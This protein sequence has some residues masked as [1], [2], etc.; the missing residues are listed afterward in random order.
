MARKDDTIIYQQMSR[1]LQ[2]STPKRN[3]QTI[4]AFG[5][6]L[7]DYLRLYGECKI[8][9]LGT[10]K[11]T[12]TPNTG[13]V[14]EVYNFATGEKEE[15]Y[16][17][18]SITVYFKGS[19]FFKCLIEQK[20]HRKATKKFNKKLEKSKATKQNKKS[21]EQIRAERLLKLKKMSQ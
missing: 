6:A 8:D 21:D 7:A 5:Q 13:C 15:R 11:A 19:E 2:G 17:E 14:R 10:F 3:K 12:Q 18:E 20:P 16:V 4:E 1:L 9:G